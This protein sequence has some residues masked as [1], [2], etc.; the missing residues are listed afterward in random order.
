MERGQEQDQVQGSVWLVFSDQG[1]VDTVIELFCDQ[2][3]SLTP[4]G[5]SSCLQPALTV[6]L[7]AGVGAQLAWRAG[8]PLASGGVSIGLAGVAGVGGGSTLGP[9]QLVVHFQITTTLQM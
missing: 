9:G 4:Q 1:T 7:V 6:Q 2:H 5:P 8:D 3:P